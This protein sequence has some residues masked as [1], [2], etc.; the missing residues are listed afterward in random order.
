MEKR[1]AAVIKEMEAYFGNDARRI[2]HAHRVTDYARQILAHERGDDEV[3]LTAAILHDIGIPEAERKYKSSA[4]DLQEQEGPPVA[5]EILA[6]LMYDAAFTDEVCAI[7]GSHHSP[8]EIETASFKVVWDADW[9]VN[10]KDE[11]SL[12]GDEV[13]RR[14]IS[15]SMLTATG[16]RLATA[17]YLQR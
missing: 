8:G 1:L 15:D 16:K 4:G 14:I 12:Q 9:L 11:P 3:A 7:I 6:R 17:L 10:L 2:S 5:R 13:R